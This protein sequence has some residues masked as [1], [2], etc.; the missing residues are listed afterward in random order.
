MHCL[1]LLPRPSPARRP[2]TPPQLVMDTII[3]VNKDANVVVNNASTIQK[4]T[5]LPH[6]LSVDTDELTPT[7]KLKR[8]FVDHKYKAAVDA[9]FVDG[10]KRAYVPFSQG[11]AWPAT[12]A[13]E[14]GG[15]GG[16]K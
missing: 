4:F 7:Y 11:G 13:E 15:G 6:D 12:A 14:G 2:A 8:D 3:A 16:A 10:E 5:I 1:F 9:M